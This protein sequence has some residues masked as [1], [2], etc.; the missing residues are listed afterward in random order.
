MG[1]PTP[2]P[3]PHTVIFEAGKVLHPQDMNVLL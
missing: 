1:V 2:P 3:P